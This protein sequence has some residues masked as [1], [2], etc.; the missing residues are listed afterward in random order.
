MPEG[1]TDMPPDD[2]NARGWH[3]DR[4]VPIALILAI[5]LQCIVGIT[6]VTRLDGRVAS[7]EQWQHDNAATN[8]RLS[9]IESRLA[10]ISTGL[11]RIV[12]KLDDAAR[13]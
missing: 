6:Y 3:L 10:D 2:P 8:V 5:A 7:L 12:S 9:V 11:N 4:R 1:N 13:R